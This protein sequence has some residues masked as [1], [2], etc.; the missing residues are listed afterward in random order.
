MSSQTVKLGDIAE[1]VRGITFKPVDVVEIGANDAIGCMRTKNVQNQIDLND[2]W[3]IS[4]NFVKNEKQILQEG[5]ILISSAN[6]WN[7]VGKGCW[8][9]KLN[10]E[11]TF[12]GFVTVLR[13]DIKKVNLKYLYHWYVKED[14]QNLLRSFGQKTTNISNLNIHRCLNLEISLPPLAEQKRI[15]AILDKANEIKAKRELALAKLDE[16][17]KSIFKEIKSLSKN[18]KKI[19]LKDATIKITD[20]THH[21][22]QITETGVPYVTAKHLKFYGLD[23]YSKPWFISKE[24]HELIYKRCDPKKRDVL[25]IKDGATTGIAAINNY[26]F[27][28][29]MLSSLALIRVDE[30]LLNPYYLKFWLNDVDVKNQ[31]LGSM[32]GAAIQR[33]TLSKI[34]DFEVPVVNI[35]IQNKFE[36]EMKEIEKNI[37]LNSHSLTNIT[38]C[39]VSLQNQAFTTGFNA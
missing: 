6:S 5:D 35:D 8:I 36:L 25:Y 11:C 4:K 9:P 38:N 3:G 33:F 18:T 30:A 26:D 13:G 1:F 28:F 22:P 15:A 16:L 17:S 31:L 37:S 10:Y 14:T 19:K 34:K 39:I 7:L 27:E 24:D 2:V 20:G 23:F 21:S 29:S 32:A 12:G